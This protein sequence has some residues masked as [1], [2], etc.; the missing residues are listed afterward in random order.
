[1]PSFGM[2]KQYWHGCADVGLAKGGSTRLCRVWQGVLGLCF[3]QGLGCFD[4]SL[5]LIF[6]GS[7][8][9][10]LGFGPC[11]PSFPFLFCKHPRG[12]HRIS[13]FAS[14]RLIWHLSGIAL[15]H[16]ACVRLRARDCRLTTKELQER[17]HSLSTF[18]ISKI[19]FEP[20]VG[21][22]RVI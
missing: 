10:C 5:F 18:R 13:L 3:N 9:G 14:D 17:S 21:A 19:L 12:R 7:G 20:S 1:M 16:V 4:T 2:H 11:F 15:R 6:T 22:E 8:V